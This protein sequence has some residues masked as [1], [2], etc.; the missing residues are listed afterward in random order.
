MIRFA[1]HEL[2]LEGLDPYL[3]GP[4]AVALVLIL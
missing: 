1:A 4:T 3:E 2:G